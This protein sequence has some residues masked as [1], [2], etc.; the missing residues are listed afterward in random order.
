MSKKV[1]E[2]T[3][4]I[5]AALEDEQIKSIVSHIKEIILNSDGKIIDIEDWGR[6]RLA[7]VVK[8]SKIGYY[9]IFRFNALPNVNSKLERF[10][11]L[12]EN[13]LRYLTIKLSEIALEQIEKNKPETSVI[14]EPVGDD[15]INLPKTE[16]RINESIET[17]EK[18]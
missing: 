12:D 17:E 8:K 5:N 15:I 10:Y 6:K 3:V 18:S 1:Y 13:I 4:L 14:K 9:V 7:Y 16:E 11:K 2:S